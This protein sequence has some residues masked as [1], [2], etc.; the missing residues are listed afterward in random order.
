MCKTVPPSSLVREFLLISGGD[1]ASVF[2]FSFH[3]F[4]G[5]GAEDGFLAA[6]CSSFLAGV[7]DLTG[8]FQ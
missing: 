7:L 4:F 5:F 1:A 3:T 2:G 8:A 6:D